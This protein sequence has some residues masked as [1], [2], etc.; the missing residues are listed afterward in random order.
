MKYRIVWSKFDQF[1]LD[2][3]FNYYAEKVSSSL[4]KKIMRQIRD[5]EVN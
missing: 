4:A 5:D 1:Q 3:I 2:V